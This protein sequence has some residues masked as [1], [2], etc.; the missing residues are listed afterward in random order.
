MN[1]IDFLR[2]LTMDKLISKIAALGV[3]D[4][5]LTVAISATGLA[6]GAAIITALAAL[7]LEG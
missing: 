6:G 2:I 1:Q 4:L 7:V 3:P 5:V